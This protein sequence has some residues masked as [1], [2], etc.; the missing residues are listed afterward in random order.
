[1]CLLQYRFAGKLLTEMIVVPDMVS[2][3]IESGCIEHFAKLLTNEKDI[4]MQEYLSAMLAKLSEDPYGN[5]FL[6]NCCSSMDFL[7]EGSQSPDPDV[8]K[9]NLEILHNLMQDP[10]AADEISRSEVR[11]MY[12]SFYF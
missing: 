4:F 11:R 9:H 12:L 8:K 1:M 6:A 2:Y 5:A 10:V 7:L 3:L